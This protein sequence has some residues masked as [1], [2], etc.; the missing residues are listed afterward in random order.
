MQ[1]CKSRISS[2]DIELIR[3]ESMS[4]GRS[5]NGDLLKGEMVTEA[6][7]VQSLEIASGDVTRNAPIP[8]YMAIPRIYA[9]PTFSTATFKVDFQLRISVNFQ[10]GRVANETIPLSLHRTT[11]DS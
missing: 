8:I 10:D 2:I 11:I 5:H 1:E 3:V 7:E 9:C 6:T 4:V